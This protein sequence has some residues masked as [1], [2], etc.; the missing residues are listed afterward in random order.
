MACDVLTYIRLK[1]KTKFSYFCNHVLSP[2]AQFCSHRDVPHCLVTTV[3]CF[4]APL[5]TVE[6]GIFCLTIICCI[7]STQFYENKDY[8]SPCFRLQDRV[9]HH[10][11]NCGGTQSF[12]K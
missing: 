8:I 5:I 11:V 1:Q 4:G 6:F 7:S 3:C 12:A 10:A 9:M 2:S